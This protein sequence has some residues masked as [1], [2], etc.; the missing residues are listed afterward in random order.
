MKNN[1][2]KRMTTIIMIIYP[3][4]QHQQQQVKQTATKD[5]KSS[6]N[7]S[8]L[9][10]APIIHL[11]RF[12]ITTQKRILSHGIN[13]NSLYLSFSPRKATNL[14]PIQSIKQTACFHVY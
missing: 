5:G 12:L 10:V 4:M 2:D 7:Q 9:S 13:A 1:T 6:N 11:S 3:M 14:T 8:T